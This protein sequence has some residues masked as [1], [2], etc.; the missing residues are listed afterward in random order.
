MIGASGATV[1]MLP[2]STTFVDTSEID[3]SRQDLTKLYAYGAYYD[4]VTGRTNNADTAVK[5][6]LP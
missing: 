3:S 6:V 1:S 2:A 5:L 4:P